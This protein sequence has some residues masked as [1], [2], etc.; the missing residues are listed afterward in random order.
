MTDVH[1]SRASLHL[2]GARPLLIVLGIALI[3]RIALLA[4]GAVSFHSDEAVVALMA[5]HLIDGARPVFFY[6]QAYM[7]SVDAWI[8]AAAF[9]LFGESVHSIRIAQSALY[10]LS[11]VVSYG[12]ARRL[13]KRTDAACVAALCLAIPPVLAALYTTATLGGY[14]EVLLFG[15]VVWWMG[16]AV[17]HGERGSLWRWALLGVCAGVGW[18]ANALIAVYA[19]PAGL[20]ILRHLARHLHRRD[21]AALRA[22]LIGIGIAAA[23]FIVGSLPWWAFNIENQW[24]GLAFL[25]GGAGDAGDFAGTD[26]FTLPL[27][28]RVA[29]FFL[30]GLPTLVGLRFPWLPS[31]F[32][33]L[34][35]VIVGI[36]FAAASMRGLLGRRPPDSP[37]DARAYIGVTLV[38]FAA[39]YL[40]SRFSFD[41]TGRYFL[42]LIIPIFIAFGAGV[43]RIKPRAL[44]FG[45]V[46]LIIGYFAAGQI[47]AA[48]SS[49][50]LTTQF[51]LETHLPND[52]DAALIAYLEAEGLTRGYSSYW[53]AF[54]LAFLSGER[55][56]FNPVL[57]Y[58]SDLT[59][60]PLDQRYPPYREAVEQAAREGLPL[61]IITANVPN[62][63][64]RI[65]ALLAARGVTDYRTTQVGIYRI[66]R[67]IPTDIATWLTDHANFL[68]R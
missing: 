28:Q 56:I 37:P 51:N 2:R 41:P 35:G 24:A 18:W 68:T 31:Y 57:P 59:Y 5:R 17:T 6:G 13:T 14:N 65:E 7:G 54:R 3:A 49:V 48:R 36:A 30:L 20:F 62:V 67:D 66:Y 11:I 34:I 25:T 1:A 15:G 43:V 50:G 47:A 53:I 29:T 10:L 19:L 42:P 23:A 27:G 8:V 9:Q 45:V 61:A 46:A 38:G 39:I 63:D 58:K 16:Y 32:A 33:P 40:A 12:A 60:T 21:G 22:T 64:A 44:A 55:L 4:S 26:V 52:D